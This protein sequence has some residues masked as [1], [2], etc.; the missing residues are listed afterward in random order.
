M[1]AYTNASL[2]DDGLSIGKQYT[3]TSSILS[4]ERP[5]MVSL[6]QDY[7]GISKLPVLYVL[8]AEEHFN[9]FATIINYLGR[10]TNIPP[11]MVVGVPNTNSRE[12]NMVPYISDWS[13]NGGG[14]DKFLAFFSNEL[15]PEIDKNYHTSGFNIIAGKSY[16]GMFAL[17]AAMQ[18]NS[19]FKAYIA[20]SPSVFLKDNQ[21]VK[22]L[23]EKRSTVA[24][25]KFIFTSHANEDDIMRKPFIEVT[26]ILDSIM[27]NANSVGHKI[28]SDEIHETVF[29]PTLMDAMHTM[30]KTF[31]VPRYTQRLG[32]D[33]IV[34]HYQNM[35]LS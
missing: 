34:N 4:E 33:A 5:Y 8:D 12:N 28:Y 19:P 2:A 13:Q 26:G 30:F 1:T 16:G 24:K 7:D 27:T 25:A 3:I 35:G 10:N 21:I 11:M 6:P 31:Q 9:I 18:E 22:D 15:I 32:V 23:W 17:Y 29:L 14:S 20:A